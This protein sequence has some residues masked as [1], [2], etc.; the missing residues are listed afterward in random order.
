MSKR[1][2]SYHQQAKA[3]Q[4][5]KRPAY[6][7]YKSKT[8]ANTATPQEL[9]WLLENDPSLPASTAEFFS[10]QEQTRARQATASL[11]DSFWKV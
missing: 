8:L 7:Q 1:T 6:E 5:E 4:A 11:P 2:D 10:Q 9:I 3:R